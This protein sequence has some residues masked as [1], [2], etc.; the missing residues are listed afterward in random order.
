MQD[1]V[2]RDPR[3]SLAQRP[4]GPTGGRQP[5]RKVPT[6]SLQVLD[7]K[8]RRFAC[9]NTPHSGIESGD[10]EVLDYVVINTTDCIHLSRYRNGAVYYLR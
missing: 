7:A 10:D 5:I 9:L 2:S 1:S 3:L 6:T 8:M 4:P